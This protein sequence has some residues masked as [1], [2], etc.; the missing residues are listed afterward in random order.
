M[1]NVETMYSSRLNGVFGVNACP[2]D[3][4]LEAYGSSSKQLEFRAASPSFLSPSAWTLENQFK[5]SKIYYF[6]SFMAGKDGP[7]RRSNQVEGLLA[8]SNAVK[9]DVQVNPWGIFKIN[10]PSTSFLNQVQKIWP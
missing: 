3:L 4:A 9:I 10:L 5:E 1:R 6:R 8:G 2:Q 7:T